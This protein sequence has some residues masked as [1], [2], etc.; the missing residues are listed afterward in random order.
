[1]TTK[2]HRLGGE[3]RGDEAGIQP[4]SKPT[5]NS[6]PGD[7]PPEPPTLA[8]V[9]AELAK[10]LPLLRAAL[11][12]QARPRVEPVA[13]RKRDVARLLSIS[14][15]LFDKMLSARRFPPADARAGKCSLWRRETLEAWLRAGGE[16]KP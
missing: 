13:Y 11:E 8:E 4:N 6:T 16:R 9:L 15:R 2:R 12:L 3:S 10:T 5:P 1:M 7:Q 14:P